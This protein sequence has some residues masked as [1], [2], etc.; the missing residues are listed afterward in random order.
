MGDKKL[1]DIPIL[2]DESIPPGEIRIVDPK[3]PILVQIREQF[4][5]L[6]NGEF[7]EALKNTPKNVL[8]GLA[9]RLNQE[10]DEQRKK[11]ERDRYLRQLEESLNAESLFLRKIKG[12]P[13]PPSA[14]VTIAA[15]APSWITAGTAAWGPGSIVTYAPA[16][17]APAA[18]TVIRN[19]TDELIEEKPKTMKKYE[20]WTIVDAV[21]AAS[22]RVLLYGPPATGKT[23][24]P[25]KLFEKQ[26]RKVF[27]ATI[28]QDT[29]SNDILGRFVLKPTPAGGSE[30]IW[31]DGPGAL[32]FKTPN[33][34]LVI[35]EIDLAGGDLN[36]LFHGLFDDPG[37]A[38]LLLPTGEIVRP[39]GGQKAVAT[40]NGTPDEL[41]PAIISRFPVTIE[42]DKVNPVAIDMLPDDLKNM[43]ANAA[44]TKDEGRRVDIRAFYEFASLRQQVGKEIAAYACF[45]PRADEVLNAL[46]V[47]SV[48]R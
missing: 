12:L 27:S 41:L 28:T 44:V 42:I 6:S 31:Q 48:K 18:H 38:Q 7:L 9:R 16:T 23:T 46:A 21:L 26:G 40:M 17:Y 45:G 15:P 2:T 32:W 20:C 19:L 34:A 5:K 39:T 13:T 14:P 10:A 30:M 37:I 11:E 36:G 4:P 22:P 43:A 29:S 24:T 35:N 1:G 3:A 8:S 25:I 47:G 33:S